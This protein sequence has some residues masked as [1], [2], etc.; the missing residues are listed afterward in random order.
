MKQ[1]PSPLILTFAFNQKAE[2]KLREID[3]PAD[4]R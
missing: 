3:D 2:L 1:N 4:S